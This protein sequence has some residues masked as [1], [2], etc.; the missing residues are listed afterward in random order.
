M[1]YHKDFTAP[2]THCFGFCSF[3]FLVFVSESHSECVLGHIS[4]RLV[5]RRKRRNVLR[6]QSVQSAADSIVL[7]T[8]H[9]SF[10][11]LVAPQTWQLPFKISKGRE[12]NCFGHHALIFSG[13]TAATIF[14][15]QKF[16][17]AAGAVFW[18]VN[19]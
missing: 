16:D 17:S 18:T 1:P 4:R 11:F 7:D 14:S 5:R 19:T 2:Q 12:R 6:S 10:D 9:F 15:F 3:I 13:A 8:Q